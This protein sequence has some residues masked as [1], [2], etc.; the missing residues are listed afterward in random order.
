MESLINGK[1]LI[2][3]HDD[4]IGKW[5]KKG[6]FYELEMLN[7]IK[8]LRLKGSFIDVGANMGNHSVF[9]KQECPGVAVVSFEPHP[10]NFNHLQKNADR[11]FFYAINAALGKESRLAGISTVPENMGM[12]KI[13]KG[14]DI[15]VLTLDDLTIDPFID[16][17]KLIKI[18]TEGMEMDVLKGAKKTLKKYKPHLFIEG[19]L[20]DLTNYLS[21]LGYSYVRSFNATPT[22]YFAING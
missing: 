10:G 12:C 16:D 8:Q 22:H 9:F 6:V 17:I 20:S 21:K 19:D 5:L 3:H 18:D 1:Y 2:S 7:F 14:N 15:N 11:F 13:E 4:H